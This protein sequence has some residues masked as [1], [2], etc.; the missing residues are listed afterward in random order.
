MLR[1]TRSLSLFQRIPLRRF[2]TRPAPNSYSL[3][4]ALIVGVNKYNDSPLW[5]S[6]QDARSVEDKLKRMG[7]ETTLLEDPSD[8]QLYESLMHFGVKR[9]PNDLAVFY[10]S[11]HGCEIQQENFL[12]AS[13]TPDQEWKPQFGKKAVVKMSLALELLALKAFNSQ[14]LVILDTCRCNAFPAQ[15]VK[16]GTVFSGIKNKVIRLLLVFLIF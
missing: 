13:E 6:I 8:S 11:G 5:C 15:A 2:T 4:Q 9:K 10:F 3:K 16:S 14:T 12:L 7:F 1:T